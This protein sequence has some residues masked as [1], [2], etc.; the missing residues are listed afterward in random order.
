MFLPVMALAVSTSLW[1][2]ND[3]IG[4]QADSFWQKK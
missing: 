4:N 1:W 2:N 3:E